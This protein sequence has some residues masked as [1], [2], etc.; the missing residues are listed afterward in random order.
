MSSPQPKPQAGQQL[1]SCT[2][3]KWNDRSGQQ[4]L[5]PAVH[6]NCHT[7]LRVGDLSWTLLQT[8]ACTRPKAQVWTESP[9]CPWSPCPEHQHTGHSVE[10]QRLLGCS[11]ALGKRGSELAQQMPRHAPS[12]TLQQMLMRE[13]SSPSRHHEEPGLR[14]KLSRL[15]L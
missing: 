12:D 4:Q 5:R 11:T 14:L 1:K 3:L 8:G 10:T 7:R 15:R 13:G 9:L 6:G 2:G